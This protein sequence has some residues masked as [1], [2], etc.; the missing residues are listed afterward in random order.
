MSACVKLTTPRC[1]V[2]GRLGQIVSGF[3]AFSAVMLLKCLMSSVESVALVVEAGSMAAPIGKFTWPYFAA[4]TVLSAGALAGL[5]SCGGAGGPAGGGVKLSSPPPQPDRNATV[6]A[7][8]LIR[9][10]LIIDAPLSF[11]IG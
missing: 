6:T 11:S 7:A 2:F 5:G 3:M 9:M 8:A 1:D 4:R 10:R